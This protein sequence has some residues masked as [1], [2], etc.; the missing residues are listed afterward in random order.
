MPNRCEWCGADAGTRDTCT[1][2]HR[3]ARWR[4]LKG[5]GNDEP[6]WAGSPLH[7]RRGELDPAVIEEAKLERELEA[8]RA[9]LERARSEKRPG[10][11]SGANARSGA[12]VSYWRAH[13][14]I[15]RAGFT[16]EGAHAILLPALGQRQREIV[17][18]R[19]GRIELGL[20]DAKR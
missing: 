10:P 2:S 12:V 16:D 5:I 17:I 15:V 4:Y 19:H 7:G 6:P 14:A 8:A 3:G 13:A 9:E 18:A 1:S 20:A 11:R